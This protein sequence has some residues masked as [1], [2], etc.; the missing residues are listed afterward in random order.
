[1][2]PLLD[3]SWIPDAWWRWVSPAKK[4][5]GIPEEI[6]RRHFE[7]CAFSQIMWELK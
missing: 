6:N 1:V 2:I 7:V 5:K 4:K 3:L